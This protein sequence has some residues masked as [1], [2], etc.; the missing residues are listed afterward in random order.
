[1]DSGKEPT[2][3][4]G[5]ETVQAKQGLLSKILSLFTGNQDP[6]AEKKRL[7]KQVNKEISKS[8][9][10]FYRPKGDEALPGMA[11]FFYEIYKIV[12][13][14][15]VLLQ[16]AEASGSLRS[17]VIDSRLKP[18]EAELVNSLSEASITELAKT[19]SLKDLQERVKNGVVQFY[20]IFDTEKVNQ[21]DSTYNTIITFTRFCM[22]DYYFLLK[23]F[24]S[25]VTERSFTYNPRF[26]AISGEYVT[27]DLKD[28]MEIFY[29][30]DFDAD[31]KRIFTD[32]K[33]Y[34]NLDVIAID[35]WL[36]LVNALREVRDSQILLYVVQAIDHNPLFES[37]VRNSNERIVDT[38]IQKVKTQTEVVVQKVIQE[39]RNGKVEE[40]ARAVFGTTAISRLKNY[41]EKANL[42]FSKKMLGGFIYIQP[43]NYLKAF[44]LDFCKKDVR[45]IIDLLIIRGQ[46]S[47]NLSSQALSDT[48]TSLMAV[49]DEV[50]K[51]DDDL[52]DDGGLGSRIRTALAKAD[53]DK[54]QIRYVR[55]LLKDTNDHALA[56]INQAAN[57]L[58]SMGRSIKNLI[59]DYDRSP[60]EL[61][62]NWKVVDSAADGKIKARLAEAYKRIYY[63]VQLMQYFVKESV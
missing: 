41:T 63:F 26:E 39:K 55:S 62:I 47:T 28:F 58:I 8:R 3:A 33:Q 6:E 59:D 7:L 34:R 43:I 2:P 18:E 12:S 29:A 52:A 31:W 19:L 40:L 30:L 42:I 44:L 27:E 23:K 51:F 54:D 56:L 24:D 4:K 36:K 5:A 45:E 48:F 17:F 1:M 20:S 15:Q 50:L 32:L 60:H 25:N 16:N 35:S 38:Y 46:W 21:I 9:Y 11:R 14:A 13:P 37:G 10:K 49:S 53:R 61:V 57:G 22:F